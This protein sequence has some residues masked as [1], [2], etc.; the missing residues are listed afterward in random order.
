MEHTV[1]GLI[2]PA[3]AEALKSAMD[4]ATTDPD[5]LSSLSGGGPVE[6]FEEAF[7]Q[8]VGAKYALALSSCTAALHVALMACGVGP[9]DDVIVSP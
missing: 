9:G 5:Y 2:S 7:A 6:E 1:A 4:K 3:Q 8:A